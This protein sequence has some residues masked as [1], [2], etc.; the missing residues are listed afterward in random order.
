MLT[1]AALLACPFA[2]V[3]TLPQAGA[4][5]DP[6][7][8]WVKANALA[9]KTPEAGNGFDDLKG[10]DAIIGDARIVSLGEPTHGTREAFQFK[11]RLL[12][13]LV[14]NKGF[15]I[16]SIEANMPESYALND[17]VIHGK[18]DPRK[19]IAGMYF[20]TWR[21]EEVL[22]MVEWMRAW[23]EKNPPSTGKPRLEFTG[24]DMQTP[25]VAWSIADAFIAKHAPD[26]VQASAPLLARVRAAAARAGQAGESA[27]WTSATGSFPVETA[28]GKKLRFSCWIRTEGVTGW[29]GAWW[30]CDTPAGV[31]GFDNMQAQNIKGDTD[32]KRYEFTID[33]PA[34]AQ[35]TSFGFILNGPGSAWF[36]DIEIE[37]DGVKYEDPEAFTFDFENDAVRYLRG[38]SAEYTIARSKTKPRG[39]TTCLEIKRRPETE[40]PKVSPAE[41]QS[42]AEKLLSDL[43]ARRDEL[44]KKTSEREADWAIQN[45]R[46]V[47]QTVA[48]YA[49]ANGFNA[50]DESMAAN[51]RWILDQ[52][53][54]RKIVLWAHNGHVSK[55]GYMAMK[56]MGANL[57]E[58]HAQ[59]MVVFGFA[60]GAGTYTAAESMA[61][62]LRSDH[63][64]V[65]PPADS[66]ERVLI[67]SGLPMAIVNLSRADRND[68][69]TAWAATN[70]PMR[71]IGALAMDQQFYPCIA[72]DMY[73]VLVWQRDTTASRTLK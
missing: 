9:F 12:E 29:A 38:G 61:G 24:F 2:V 59:D 44:A 3:A 25:D 1:L 39:G 52:N 66:I 64:L 65:E 49:S 8:A 30:R 20:W 43:L 57:R 55:S 33:V 16:F 19:L 15:S 35:A 48:M 14:E 27:G 28:R 22:A 32:W 70:R 11:H 73:D 26:L 23:N 54:G 50:R 18:G 72:A 60:T 45:A 63:K 21:T 62:S 34:D 17:Y 53:P 37:L 67:D 6:A 41:V 47:A 68:P 13:Y 36:D 10:L 46:I 51:V 31:N 69:A 71:S 4:E 42:E 40:I 5:P 56:S 7:A 58:T